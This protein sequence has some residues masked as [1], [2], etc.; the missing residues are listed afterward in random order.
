MPKKMR[1]EIRSAVP[2]SDPKIMEV[3]ADG[4]VIYH[5]QITPCGAV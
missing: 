4:A 1:R 2:K 5:H 3:V